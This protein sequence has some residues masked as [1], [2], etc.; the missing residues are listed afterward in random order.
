MST[1][2]ERVLRFATAFQ[3]AE[4]WLRRVQQVPGALEASLSRTDFKRTLIDESRKGVTQVCMQVW[5]LFGQ[6]TL[7][8]DS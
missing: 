4:R 6:Q 5:L 3:F 1:S 2:G 7:L 8:V